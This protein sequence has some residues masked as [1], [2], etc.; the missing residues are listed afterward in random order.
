M[1]ILHHFQPVSDHFELNCTLTDI[2]FIVIKWEVI[3]SKNSFLITQVNLE[4][5]KIYE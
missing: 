3:T 4:S 5:R 2:L 1:V